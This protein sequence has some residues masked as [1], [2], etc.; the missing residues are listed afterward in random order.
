MHILVFGASI[1][2]GAWDM[3]GGWVQRLRKVLDEKTLSDPNFYCLTYNLGVSGDTTEDALR[4]FEFETKQRTDEG[5]EIIFIFAIGSND[6]LFVHSKNSCKKKPAET[7]ENVV[8]LIK[9]AQKY[10]S[11]IIFVGLLPADE[12]KTKPLE[13]DA[14]LSYKN[15]YIKKYNE[16]IKKT[17]SENKIPFIDMFDKLMES[18]YIK[19]L[20]DGIH[21]NS[22]GHQKIF[23]LVREY[24]VENKII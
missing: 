5:E 12:A 15:E 6:S 8:Q 21:P 18:D 9:L 23:E 2:Y 1:T 10:A 14:N 4:R 22:E 11:K 17:C 3:E 24:L 13:W 16:V 7:K 20:D 19:T